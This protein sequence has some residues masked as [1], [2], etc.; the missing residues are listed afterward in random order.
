MA[1]QS[2]RGESP[3]GGRITSSL[4][5]AGRAT[6]AIV[7]VVGD[8][9]QAGLQDRPQPA[10]YIPIRQVPFG[11]VTFVV[12]TSGDPVSVI[13]RLQRAVWAINPTV[14][15]AGVE[16]MNGLLRETL[17]ARRF[18]LTR[19]STF[20]IA[21]LVLASVVCMVSSASRLTSERTKSASA[22]RWAPGP[23][24]CLRWSCGRG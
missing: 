7:G 5:F 20:S 18:T 11:S 23:A 13:P 22:W 8:V 16:T 3:V 19:L 4:S 9:R 15:F 14:T 24:P 1:R 17:A 12:R 10:Y 21:A 6:R 2:W